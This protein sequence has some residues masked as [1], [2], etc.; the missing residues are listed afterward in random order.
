M[1]FIRVKQV[2]GDARVRGLVGGVAGLAHVDLGN[3][4]D[5]S[6]VERRRGIGVVG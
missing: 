6:V 5:A 2:T 3:V 4:D 1:R